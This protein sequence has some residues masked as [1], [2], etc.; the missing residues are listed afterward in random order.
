MW[1]TN[2][3]GYLIFVNVSKIGRCRCCG[4]VYERHIE[5][6]KSWQPDVPD[7]CPACGYENQRVAGIAFVNRVLAAV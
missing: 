2:D 5:D 7:R 3:D 6:R 1:T 4:Q